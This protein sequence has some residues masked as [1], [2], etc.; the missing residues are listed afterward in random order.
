[1]TELTKPRVDLVSIVMSTVGFGCVT[2]GFSQTSV[3]LEPEGYGSIAIGSL[4]LLLLVWRQL[5]NQ[6]AVDRSFSIPASHFFS[7]CGIDCNCD[8][9]SIRHNNIA[10]VLYAG[11][12][13]VDSIR[14][15]LTS[16]AR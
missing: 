10:A 16:N 11:C 7:G 4:F 12:D 1:M 13:E 5:K 6:R 3:S 2:Y 9:G 15:R 8:D 14:D